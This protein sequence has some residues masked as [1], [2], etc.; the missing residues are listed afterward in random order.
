VTMSAFLRIGLWVR[1]FRGVLPE[2]VGVPEDKFALCVQEALGRF[3]RRWWFLLPLVIEVCLV[4]WLV[5]RFSR[6]LAG[7]SSVVIAGAIAGVGSALGSLC[8]CILNACCIFRGPVKHAVREQLNRNGWVVCLQ[9]GYDLRGQ[10]EPRCPECGTFSPALEL[11]LEARRTG[12]AELDRP[13]ATPP[14]TQ[15]TPDAS[16]R[17]TSRL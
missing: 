15:G 13:S 4:I 6:W 7:D 5:G 11:D 3:S 17:E 9:C 8:L 1:L 2:A 14:T 12:P 16:G 10:T